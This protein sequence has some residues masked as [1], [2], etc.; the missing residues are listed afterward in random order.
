VACDT[1][2]ACK[3]YYAYSAIF[4][5]L[6]YYFVYLY[7]SYV[8]E[9]KCVVV[10]LYLCYIDVILCISTICHT[11]LSHD[12]T[13]PF[14]HLTFCKIIQ[15]S[16]H[17]PLSVTF[18]IINLCIYLG[19]APCTNLENKTLLCIIIEKLCLSSI[20]KKG[21]IKSASR[22]SCGSWRIDDQQLEI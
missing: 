18:A 2:M 19:G 11:I 15:L 13:H 7:I 14:R 1:L 22:P 10:P 16:S 8:Y 17:M 6:D 12:Y 4:L 9:M 20:T 3:T 21:E 5:C